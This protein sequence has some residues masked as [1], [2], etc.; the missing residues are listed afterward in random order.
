MQYLNYWTPISAKLMPRTACLGWV[1]SDAG[2]HSIGR[3]VSPLGL[4]DL[5]RSAVLTAYPSKPSSML[6]GRRLP[7]AGHNT[8]EWP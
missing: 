6:A 2:R 4:A 3:A 7:V 8:P 1:D 5:P